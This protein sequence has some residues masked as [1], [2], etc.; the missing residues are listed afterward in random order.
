MVVFCHNPNCIA[1]IQTDE[2]ELTV[3]FPVLSSIHYLNSE[4]VLRRY[5]HKRKY[6]CSICYGVIN[7]LA[8]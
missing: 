4:R 2:E 7:C 1:N 6:F 8:E 3:E 5:K